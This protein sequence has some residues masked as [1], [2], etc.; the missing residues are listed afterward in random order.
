MSFVSLFLSYIIHGEKESAGQVRIRVLVNL[1][2][3]GVGRRKAG[4]EIRIFNVKY[5]CKKLIWTEHEEKCPCSLV[6][7]EF[8]LKFRLNLTQTKNV[9]VFGEYK[10]FGIAS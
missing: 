2:N 10:C 7:L 6:A 5:S 9:F 1:N 8:K 4:R 3:F